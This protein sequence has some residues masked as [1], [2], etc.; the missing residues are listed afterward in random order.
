[1]RRSIRLIA[2]APFRLIPWRLRRRL[3]QAVFD[4]TAAG[5]PRSAMRA[6][7]QIDDDLTSRVNE[8]AISYDSGVHV[9][10]RLMRYHDF[11]VDRIHPGERVLDL[12]C[13][14]GAVAYSIASRVDA[15]VVGI[16]LN[17][18][19]I[20]MARARFGLPNLEFIHGD[21]LEERPEGAFDVI[22][23]S[24][25]LEHIEQRVGFLRRLL[26]EVAPARWLIRV[27]LYN[28]DWRVPLR[29]ELKLPYFSDAT[30][31][32]EYTVDSFEEELSQ[33]GL[34]IRQLQVAWGEIWA[35]AVTHA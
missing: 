19:H 32:T 2:S 16:D 31:F 14:Y 9:K 15:Q 34:S 6:L 30:H 10:H 11:F 25:L 22:V 29:Q 20:A 3:L 13:G 23:L 5:P 28:R 1:V 8:V 7:L 33:A 12:G 17:A 35:E 4:A 21:A 26:G 27:P 24:N 18:E